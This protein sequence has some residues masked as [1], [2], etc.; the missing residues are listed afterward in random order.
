MRIIGTREV[1]TPILLG[2]LVSFFFYPIS[3]SFLPIINTKMMLA[4]VGV[5]MFGFETLRGG[6]GGIDWDVLVSATIAVFFSLFCF[7]TAYVNNTTDDSYSS[8]I[9]T[10]FVWTFGGYTVCHFLR[11][12]YG[13]ANLR[14]IIHYLAAVAVFQ[15]VIA[16]VINYSP[17]VRYFVDTYILQD[18]EN[19]REIKRIYGIGASLDNAGVRFSITL[20]LIAFLIT[21][22]SKYSGR[23][24]ELWLLYLSFILITVLGNM[25]SRTTTVGA[26]LGISYLA[27]NGA[28]NFGATVKKSKL[29]SFAI[30]F[31]VL[32]A[33]VPIAAYLYAS[34]AEVESQMRFAFEGFFNL[35]E[36]GDFR[37]DSTDKLNGTMW[38]W[39]DDPVTWM[40]GS[41]LFGNWA[42][43]TDVGYCRFI[44]YCGLIGFGIFAIFFIHNGLAVTRK[45]KG[46]WMLGLMLIALTFII[47]IKVSTDIFLIYALLIC[48]DPII[49]D[50]IEETQPADTPIPAVKGG[51]RR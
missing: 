51:R 22:T 10:F 30:A 16:Q 36:T 25:I 6:R 26:I 35:V 44:L 37:T 40:I 1:I 11:K 27:A 41:G 5:T 33:C 43:G 50:D 39:P 48:A 32:L 14:I 18:Q 29:S 4:A 15:C 47:W 3:F 45:F 49:R 20:V 28:L 31:L 42:F 13:S 21:D 38:I 7:I 23:S 46:T 19:L 2:M 12:K 8:Y 34:N 9:L 24:K 17:V